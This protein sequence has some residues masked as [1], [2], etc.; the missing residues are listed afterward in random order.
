MNY[1][2]KVLVLCYLPALGEVLYGCEIWTIKLKDAKRLEAF[3][4]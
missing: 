2:N 3:K 4:M 1:G